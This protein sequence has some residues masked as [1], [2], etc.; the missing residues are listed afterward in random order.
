MNEKVKVAITCDIDEEERIRLLMYYHEA[1]AAA[2]AVPLIVPPYTKEKD[3]SEWLVCTGV[4]GVLLTGG[5]DVNPALYGEGWQDG[6]GRVSVTRDAYEFLLLKIALERRL[7]VL[8]ICRG[9]Q[10]INV[11][12]GGTLVQDMPSLLGK[13]YAIHDQ[14]VP[15]QLPVHRVE[16]LKNSLMES[17]FGCGSLMTNSHHHQCVGL[18]GKGLIAS[19]HTGDGVVQALETLDGNVAAVQFHPERMFY[20]DGCMARFFL[21]WCGRLK[22]GR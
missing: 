7:P 5:A 18:L 2:G 11:A 14:S 10:V 1:V 22:T 19:G 20:T 16:F 9:L 12:F 4:D 21:N 15:T 17:L 8:G 3:L 6:L 13:D